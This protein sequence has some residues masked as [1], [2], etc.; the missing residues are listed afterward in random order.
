MTLFMTDC[1]T[2]VH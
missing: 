2:Y 1:E